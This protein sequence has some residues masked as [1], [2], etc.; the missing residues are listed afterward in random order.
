MKR[1]AFFIGLAVG[2]AALWGRLLAQA[3]APAKPA[4]VVPVAAVAT[5]DESAQY[6]GVV[7]QYCAGCHN[8]RVT[9][10]ATASGVVFDTPTADLKDIGSNAAMWEKVVRKMRAGAMPPAGVPHPDVKV[11]A[12]LLTF[13]ETRLDQ[14]ATTPNPGRPVLHRLNRTEYRNAI[15]D[16]LNLEIGDVAQLLPPDDSAYGFDKIADF[17]GVSQTLLERYLSAAGRISALAVGDTEVV[18]GSETYSARQDLSQDK[19]LDGMPFG[20]V[21]GIKVTHNFPVDG[22]YVL[23]ATLF[24]TNVDVTRG[25]EFPRQME[26]AVDGERVFLHT[27]GGEAVTQP[28]EDGRRNEG[29]GRARLLPR[30]DQIDLSLQVRV[31]V[32]AGP[33]DLTAA[34]LQRSRAADPRKM[35]PYR[36]SF[37]TYDATGIPHVETLIVKGPYSV[38]A[39]GDTPSRARVFTCR[40]KTPAQEET[41]ARQILT[42]LVRRAYRQPASASDVNRVMDFYR[43]SRKG[44]GT[45]DAGIQLAL[46]RVLASPKF[47]LRVE[48]DPETV[49]AGTAY[50]ISDVELA[51]RLSFF[52]WSSIP[53]DELLSVAAKGTLRQPAVLEQQVRRMLHDPRAESLV[54]NFAAQWLQL[55]NLQRITPD[56][57]LFPEFDDNLRQSFRREVEL[58]FDT[59]MRE[60]RSVLDLLNADYTFVDERLA[61]HYGIPN[62]YGSHF[63]RITVTDDARKGLLG[64]GAILAVTS[65]ADRT[66]PVVRGKWI[67]DNL[68]GMPPPAPPAVVPPLAASAGTADK[69]KSMRDQM[70]TH[71]ANAV[72]ASC[73]KLMDPIGLAME[74]FDAVGR[75]RTKDAAGPID[76][77]GDLIDGT[78]VDGIVQLRQALLK[79]PDVFVGTMTEKLLTYA[80]ERGVE[81]PD[82]PTVRGIVRDATKQDYRFSALVLG[83][84]QSPAFQMRLKAAEPAL[85]TAQR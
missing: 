55:R 67:L 79:R 74:N 26:L 22:D 28:G 78:H 53:D 45:F 73:H 83:V 59:I 70:A 85:R 29:T 65:N 60:D 36:S 7:K 8:S 63:R 66:S 19:H 41:C 13:L 42:T 17:L 57:D 50:K 75:W 38:D 11:S 9:T 64:K 12:G 6:N 35:Q 32:T 18:P 62:V 56:N 49:A 54:E 39:I 52:I 24:R 21:G 81:A 2:V 34:F 48:R 80:I 5:A 77:T 47:V 33:K 23:Q 51:S 20:T 84:V 25:L 37:D 71:R 68:Q 10:S 15:R 61:R 76:A 46:Q 4:A 40:P 30:S 69:P 14:S 43:S 3:P 82:M 58:I 1:G 72:C 27:I 44:G 16:L 31:H